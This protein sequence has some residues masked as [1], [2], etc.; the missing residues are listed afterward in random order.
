MAAYAWA[1]SRSLIARLWPPLQ[2]PNLDHKS[3]IN[4]PLDSLPSRSRSNERYF[5]AIKDGGIWLS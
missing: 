3:P 1:K 2:K 5:S 4:G